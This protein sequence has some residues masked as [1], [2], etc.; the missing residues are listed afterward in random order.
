MRVPLAQIE[1]ET[2]TRLKPEV[3]GSFDALVNNQ[4]RIEGAADRP[5]LTEGLQFDSQRQRA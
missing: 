1:V 3:S 4:K 2:P 5:A